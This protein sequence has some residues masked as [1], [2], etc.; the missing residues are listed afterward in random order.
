MDTFHH[1]H[2][3]WLAPLVIVATLHG[4]AS[5]PTRDTTARVQAL[6]GAPF[7]SYPE[8]AVSASNRAGKLP[9]QVEVSRMGAATYGVKIPLPAARGGL[10]P[11]LALRYSSRGSNGLVGMGW[12]IG[13]MS[14]VHR[15]RRTMRQDGVAVGVK[16][17]GND[18][19]FCVDGQRIE[20]VH[21][22][23]GAH[24]TEYRTH[25]ESWS[26]ITSEGSDQGEPIRFVVETAD[27]FTKTYAARVRNQL[28][29]TADEETG[30]VLRSSRE[31]TMAWHLSTVEDRAGNRVEYD[32]EI[33]RVG[34]TVSTRPSL[35]AYNLRP[36]ERAEEA[37][38]YV[39]FH[40]ESRSDVSET[41]SAGFRQR[42]DSRLARIDIYAPRLGRADVAEDAALLRRYEL[43]YDAG[44]VT[45]RSLL[46]SI[47]QCDAAGICQWPTEFEWSLGTETDVYEVDV[48]DLADDETD[49]GEGHRRF[50]LIDIDGDSRQDLLYPDGDVVCGEPTWRCAGNSN[51][52]PSS[53]GWSWPR[54]ESHWEYRRAYVDGSGRPRFSGSIV[55]EDTA[56]ETFDGSYAA[57]F[58]DVD[59][60]GV[61]ELIHPR[62]GAGT[63]GWHLFRRQADGTYRM[64]Q[65]LGG[66]F[67]SYDA[68]RGQG[69]GPSPA[70]IA[71]IDGD[72][73]PDF[74]RLDTDT[75]GNTVGKWILKRNTGVFTH[76][77]D[78]DED[79]GSPGLAA[80]I[81][82][83]RIADRGV[84]VLDPEGDGSAGVTSQ[85]IN[86]GYGHAIFGNSNRHGTSALLPATKRGLRFPDINGDGLQ[87]ALYLPA[88]DDDEDDRAWIRLGLGRGGY[89]DVRARTAQPFVGVADRGSFMDDGVRIVDWNADGRDDV[90]IMRPDGVFTY[91]SE[92]TGYALAPRQGSG[93]VSGDP[94]Y[95][96]WPIQFGDLDGDGLA[97]RVAYNFRT[98]RLQVMRRTEV[99]DRIVRVVDGFGASTDIEYG[100][101]SDNSLYSAGSGCAFPIQCSG[102]GMGVVKTLRVS[103]PENPEHV[104]RYRYA[105]A[106][107]DVQGG[108]HLGFRFWTEQ[109]EALGRW[110]QREWDVRTY[111][112]G[113]YAGLSLPKWEA[114]VFP[115]PSQD[116]VWLH[117]VENR[118]E[119]VSSGATVEIRMLGGATRDYLLRGRGGEFEPAT[120]LANAGTVSVSR[121]VAAERPYR[122]ARFVQS[123]FVN[124]TPGKIERRV[125]GGR[126]STLTQTVAP[127]ETPWLPSL[128]TTW[129]ESFDD[130]AARTVTRSGTMDYDQRGFLRRTTTTPGADE[131]TATQEF[132]RDNAGQVVEIIKRAPDLRERREKIAY[133]PEG[134][135]PRRFENALGHVSW[136]GMHPGF[137]APLVEVDPNG[138]KTTY[139]Y[140][141][142]GRLSHLDG[143]TR[144]FDVHY[145][146]A[147]YQTFQ[148]D[149]Y[150]RTGQVERTSFDPFG[151]VTSKRHFGFDGQPVFAYRR[152]DAVG[153]LVAAS[154][155][156]GKERDEVESWQVYSYDVMGR[157]LTEF[158][159]GDGTTFHSYEALRHKVVDPRGHQSRTVRDVNGDV[160]VASR[161]L[162]NVSTEFAYGPLGNLVSIVDAAGHAT[163]IRRDAYGRAVAIQDPSSGTKTT[164]FDAFGDMVETVRAEGSTSYS[165]D[166]LGRLTERQGP[167]ETAFFGWDTAV[168]GVGKLA[169]NVSRSADSAQTTDAY[170][171]YDENGRIAQLRYRFSDASR[172]QI[173]YDYDQHGRLSH[174]V[175]PM[176]RAAPRP[177]RLEIAYQYN[178][179]GYLSTV[180]DARTDSELWRLDARDDRGRIAAE[181]FGNGVRTTRTFD[182]LTGRMTALQSGGAGAD[183]QDLGF[184]YDR[185]GNLTERID[186]LG[187][188]RERMTYDTF[189]RLSTWRVETDK[190]TEQTFYGYDTIGNL[191]SRQTTNGEVSLFTY[192][193]GNA[194]PYA[195]TSVNERS[196]RYDP[197]GRQTTAPGRTIEF[198]SFDLPTTIHTNSATLH[199]EY[200]A[201]GKRASKTGPNGTVKYIGRLCEIHSKPGRTQLARQVCNVPGPDSLVAQITWDTDADEETTRYFHDEGLG[202]AAVVTDA[203]GEVTGRAY[204]SPFGRRV[205]Q[206]G[207]PIGGT[208]E[209]GVS[210]HFTGHE[211]D[212]EAGLINMRG[213]MYDPEIGRF[214]S[215]DPFVQN[216]FMGQGLNRYSY[217]INNPFKYIDPTGLYRDYSG[218]EDDAEYLVY[219]EHDD[220][221]TMTELNF[222]FADQSA[223]FSSSY[224]T[225][226]YGSD[227][228]SG[229]E[230]YDDGPDY[231]EDPGWADADAPSFDDGG[232]YAPSM[233]SPA[234]AQHPDGASN[235]GGRRPA[236]S[237]PN[238][239]TVGIGVSG[240]AAMVIGIRGSAIAYTGVDVGPNRAR[241][242]SGYA[243]SGGPSLGPD[244][245]VSGGLVLM[246]T[247][248][249]PST[250]EGKTVGIRGA[251]EL[252]IGLSLGVEF[253]LV[254]S[255]REEHVDWGTPIITFGPGIGVG[256]GV[257]LT[258]SAGT[259][260]VTP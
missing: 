111:Q 204:Y 3:R 250:L 178:A 94:G 185:N 119:P 129:T 97:E 136:V 57:I 230:F 216:A 173:E 21:G 115:E 199:F 104:R 190:G 15:C 56:G 102:G 239:G 25:I 217:V 86:L 145:S 260:S 192:G 251:G 11:P 207:A 155:P 176:V 48:D 132:V 118:V 46:Q 234:P 123:E 248:G 259:R 23:Y 131:L 78:F 151:R 28:A 61:P 45:G 147:R 246:W 220:D 8:D 121:I 235:G 74:L 96:A 214:L 152:Y 158:E 6:E 257:A 37:R 44:S 16:F 114:H 83:S 167:T 186:R 49:E 253:P 237:D 70:Y 195:V 215:A 20:A 150:D 203:N 117:L 105:D 174:I 222:E 182:E 232:T 80:P 7:T 58:V 22:E 140:D 133:G 30:E 55:L 206:R 53:C 100:S 198:N 26:R 75:T 27:G 205:D 66:D 92:G 255:G 249:A 89:G 208:V 85:A 103:S 223:G 181:R 212:E 162:T 113:V 175:Y 256:A 184:A 76:V 194:G 4:C 156:T 33:E 169:R 245:Q 165:Y 38:R 225:S 73:L 124:G 88:L 68:W 107:I 219:T 59:R 153:R 172:H 41:Y 112:D 109:D 126:G 161:G 71:D 244:I 99:P 128:V 63:V 101:T 18:V 65:H 120:V 154:P 170:Y 258:H 168:N 116:R 149:R 40:Y 69:K 236:Y 67:E 64:Q 171:R 29:L 98:G 52:H 108:G 201:F 231:S 50:M 138:V 144:G 90:V 14:R 47:R 227:W 191:V 209:S 159:P 242:E 241:Q 196:Y 213:R 228:D 106:R 243:V 157:I 177:E 54:C 179:V 142:F 79:L 51:F 166:A 17:E 164:T 31:P 148:T 240:D 233:P 221:G 247:P 12:S 189:D 62:D 39:R 77:F 160:V 24:G 72:S 87:D 146:G 193:G 93:V 238:L 5:E 141:G 84:Y 218:N 224:E 137:G 82:R 252:G 254:V 127:R 139:R 1:L 36:G 187:F 135:F 163:T 143:A 95:G 188:R 43:A 134:V 91:L 229:S 35:I 2:S 13:G 202:S 226:D 211:L 183:L 180:L 19:L 110:T 210:R 130:G 9:G 81:N 10:V 125:D 34:S 32:Y 60:D 200:D 42:T 197:M 122:I